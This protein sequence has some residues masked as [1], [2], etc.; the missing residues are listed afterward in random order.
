MQGFFLALFA[1]TDNQIERIAAVQSYQISQI[2]SKGNMGDE[3]GHIHQ[4]ITK[5][6]LFSAIRKGLL[7]GYTVYKGRLYQGTRIGSL[8]SRRVIE[9]I[10]K[11][12]GSKSIGN[13]IFPYLH[14]VEHPQHTRGT[15][16]NRFPKRSK[17]VS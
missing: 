15:Q 1:F 6:H 7:R 3:Q 8:V 9:K 5:K 4:A 16:D 10:H 12:L 2:S 17:L 14:G 11:E 13:T